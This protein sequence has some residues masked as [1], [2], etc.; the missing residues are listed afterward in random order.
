MDLKKTIPRNRRMN[1]DE[2]EGESGNQGGDVA[3][4]SILNKQSLNDAPA[5]PYAIKAKP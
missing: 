4:M 1:P 3:D 5:S 2:N